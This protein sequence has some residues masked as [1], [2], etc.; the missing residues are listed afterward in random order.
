MHV[1]TIERLGREGDGLAGALRLPFA[2]PGERWGRATAEC[3][4]AAPDAGAPACP[5]FGAC[6]GC[7]L[8]HASDGFARGVEARDR[9]SGRWRRG[10]S[11]R[12]SAP[13]LTSPPRSRRRAVFAG[14]RTRKGALLGF[15]GRRSDALVELPRCLVVRPEILAAL[16]GAG[17]SSRPSVHRAPADA[18]ADRHQR[19][20]RARRRR[21][22][23]QAAR[24]RAA[25][26]ARGA[27]RTRP[28]SPGW[29]GTARRWSTRRPPFQRAGRGA[30]RAAAGGLPA[31]D[32]RGRGG[33]GGG[34]ARRGRRRP[35]GRR[36][37][38]RLRHL[39]AAA[40]RGGRGACAVEGDA[41]MPSRR[42]PPAGAAAPGLRPVSVEARDLFRRPLLRRRARRLRR[43]RHR[44][45]ARR[46][47]GPE[48]RSSRARACRLIAAVSC[49]PV[50][51]ARDAAILVAG[52][53]RLDWVQPVDQFRWSG[54]VELA[55]RFSR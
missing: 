48:P 22:R 14:R 18:A 47:R 41:A 53:Y 51:F 29:P 46:R 10:A 7:A 23:R 8:Q 40:G 12:R 13:T 11:R 5:H 33:A 28:T 42:S 19:A 31:G 2:L 49:D 34:G 36:P 3:S 52:G 37:L 15:H 20:G 6:G 54:H 45:A 35:A 21:R 30:G 44:P 4:T 9:S 38:R 43:G 50:S 55:A 24:R 39:H 1:V 27:R 32:R 17:A 25:R 16:P 26:R